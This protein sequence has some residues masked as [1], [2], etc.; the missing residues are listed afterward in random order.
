MSRRHKI[1]FVWFL[2][3]WAFINATGGIVRELFVSNSGKFWWFLDMG[4]SSKFVLGSFVHPNNFGAYLCIILP[5][6]IVFF[7]KGYEEV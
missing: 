6:I 5:F 7:I 2:I 4:H 1:V 3:S